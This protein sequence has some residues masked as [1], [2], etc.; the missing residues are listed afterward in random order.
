MRQKYLYWTNHSKRPLIS[1][2]I[3]N[4]SPLEDRQPS[5]VLRRVSHLKQKISFINIC[6]AIGLENKITR[7]LTQPD[8]RLQTGW[9]WHFTTVLLWSTVLLIIFYWVDT[10]FHEKKNFIQNDYGTAISVCF[11]TRLGIYVFLLVQSGPAVGCLSCRI[12]PCP[13]EFIAAAR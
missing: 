5:D 2:S 10:T 6:P 8:L 9:T 11:S 12:Y 3:T 1:Y 13:R 7:N 4:G